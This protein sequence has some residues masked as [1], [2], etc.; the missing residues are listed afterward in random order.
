MVIYVFSL[1]ETTMW[2]QSTV[3][4]TLCCYIFS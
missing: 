1:F 3:K 4:K 2:I